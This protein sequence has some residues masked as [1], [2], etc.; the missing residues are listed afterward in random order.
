MIYLKSFSLP[1][2]QREAEFI[3]SYPPELEMQCYDNNNAYPFKLFPAKKLDHISF[4]PITVLY[5]GNGSGKSTIL[6]II[7][8]KLEISRSS[9]F[10]RAPCF[11]KYLEMCSCSFSPKVG[12][13]IVKGR[14]ITSDDV[15]DFLLD[16]RAMNE[17]ISERREA[18]FSEYIGQR[19]EFYSEKP[20][21]SIEDYESLKQRNE[22]KR[23]SMSVYTAKRLP[24]EIPT[25][26]NGE[27]AYHYFTDRIGENAL[28]L[29]DEPE[30]S[31]SASLQ[32]ELLGFLED[33]ARFYNCQF[34]I[35]TH[36][37][38]LL[39]LKD[40]LVYDLD[41]VPVQTK[42]WTELENVRIYYDFF[43][44]HEYEFR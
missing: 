5:G 8:E 22:A 18:L 3:L 15:F 16:R 17:G 23:K 30:N 20:F 29:L 31:L 40:A 12:S 14:I 7:A 26:S 34:I 38:F 10:N 42:N 9:P 33:S 44:K 6:N 25:R 11:S 35:S 21:T 39:S 28:Y 13:A 4:A 41:S 43:K 37:P 19:T 27:S 1:S 24:R 36:S 32:T 2:E